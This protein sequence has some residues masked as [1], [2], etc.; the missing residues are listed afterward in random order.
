MP[1]VDVVPHFREFSRQWTQVLGLLDQGLLGTAHPLPEARLIFELA[2]RSEWERLELRE[3]LE[4]DDSFLTRLLA[5]LQRQGLIE[6]TASATDGRRKRVA[7]TAAGR[8]EFRVLDER[9]S[10]QV[11]DLVSG[12]APVQRRNLLD[13]MSTTMRL[14]RRAPE[15]EV[16]I[17]GLG[18]GDLGWV[19]QRHGEIYWNEFGWDQTFEGLVARIV[20]DHLANARP[21]RAAA[22]IA[23]VDGARAGCVFC[24]EREPD[25]AQLR[26]LLV[27]PWARGLGL[28]A[29]LVR[30]C[31]EFARWAGYV[32]IVLW[33][34]DVLV[35]ARRIY[36][37]AG[38]ELVEE[39]PH[40][41]FGH[42]L[43]GQTWSLD[44]AR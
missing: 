41:S 36:Q 3:R 14:L 26:I 29:R 38:F 33:T 23:E 21:R 9:S 44:L 42:D 5:S 1:A 31:I 27:E 35:A 40:H 17:R 2:Q 25:V 32:K 16:T 19:V 24:C 30:E 12:L 43:V 37:A 8:E 7:L 22:W 4:I 15:P 39:E 28:G 13:A 18:P 20:A 10:A 6:I 11:E 34:N